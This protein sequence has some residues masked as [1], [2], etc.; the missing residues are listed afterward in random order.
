MYTIC[1]RINYHWKTWWCI[2]N[3]CIVCAFLFIF[4]SDSTKVEFVQCKSEI[5]Q[6]HRQRSQL[7]NQESTT[8]R[9]LKHAME[10]ET[11]RRKAVEEENELLKRQLAAM[12]AT[13]QSLSVTHST[14]AA[15]AA[16]SHRVNAT[17]ATAGSSGSGVG[18]MHTSHTK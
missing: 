18:N 16:T 12:T 14:S 3:F 5:H 13:F 2:Y 4:F 6:L 11:A 10:V 1:I 9:S 17:T 7:E 15:S 8:L